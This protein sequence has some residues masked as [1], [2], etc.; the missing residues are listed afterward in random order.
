MIIENVIH[1]IMNLYEAIN[2]ILHDDKNSISFAKLGIIHP[3][4][5]TL[6]Q[7]PNEWKILEMYFGKN[8]H[9]VETNFD[10]TWVHSFLITIKNEDNL[11]P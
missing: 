3:R 1:Q 8:N 9:H 2:G 6:A 10:N 7:L 4:I 11:K 5:I